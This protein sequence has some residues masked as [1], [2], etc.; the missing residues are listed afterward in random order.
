MDPAPDV[1]SPQVYGNY[2][3]LDSVLIY[4][5]DIES[6]IQRHQV[7]PEAFETRESLNLLA[8]RFDLPPSPTFP[9]FLAR[10]DA[11]YPTIRSYSLPNADPETI[12]LKAA[13]AGNL[14]A[15]YLGLRLNPNYKTPTLLNQAL[16]LAAR[17]GHQVMIDLIKDLDGTSFKEEVRGTAEGGHLEKLKR[18]IAQGPELSQH[19]LYE[20]T[21]DAVKFGQ[22]ATVKY[23][24]TLSTRFT[25]DW[26]DL[27]Y[28]AGESGNQ[29]MV[30][31]IISQGGSNYTDL[32]KGAIRQGHLELAMRY[33]DKPG[34]N[35]LNI[36]I[37]AILFNYLDLA[38]F[39]ARD[40]R[41]GRD[42]LN[43][44][45]ESV[46]KGTTYETIDYLISLGGD[47]YQ[48]LV[49]QLARN[50]LIK[51]FKR[52]Y[53]IPDLDYNQIFDT[54]LNYSSV[55]IVKFMLEQQL[56]PITGEKLNGYL[57]RV[58]VNPELIELLLSLGATDYRTVVERALIFGNLALAKKYLV[59]APGLSL[60]SIFRECTKIPVYQYLM[61]Q[62]TIT[63]KTVDATLARL[64]RSIGRVKAKKYLR[65][66]SLQDG[67][68]TGSSSS[69]SSTD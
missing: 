24:I 21:V 27:I 40:R 28:S 30:D 68:S 55:E 37:S 1:F 57:R 48:G 67:G 8:R 2:P 56:V 42:S 54:G 49:S 36:F 58:F 52:Y 9:A 64:K 53:L 50:D 43:D 51:L 13:E 31:Y 17:G 22:L 60:N 29:G 25:T 5:L 47:N 19:R 66:L 6:I 10:Y 41:I 61:S 23:L 16:K 34:L 62:G 18:L 26:N 46:K 32:I 35:Y 63:Q 65:S 45:M 39:V 59:Q 3:V 12:I 15:F 4:D 20:F 38:K 7:N 33:M 44:L 69:S 14:Q 11:K